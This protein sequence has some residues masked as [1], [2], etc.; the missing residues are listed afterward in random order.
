MIGTIKVPVTRSLVIVLSIATGSNAS[1]NA[2]A[3]Q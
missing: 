2:C 1:M 3:A